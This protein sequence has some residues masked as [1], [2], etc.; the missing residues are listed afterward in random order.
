MQILPQQH[1]FPPEPPRKRRRPAFSCVQCRRR[2]VKCDREEPCGPCSR[3]GGGGGALSCWYASDQPDGN[4]NSEAASQQTTNQ[5]CASSLPF[6]N[7]LPVQDGGLSSYF[8]MPSSGGSAGGMDL[9]GL[10]DRAD[11]GFFPYRGTV[12]SQTQS[13][14]MGAGPEQGAPAA[15]VQAGMQRAEEP[16]RQASAG[17]STML[18]PTTS[19]TMPYLQS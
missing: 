6:P 19:S 3:L 8:S 18:M 13:A 9:L 12:A 16:R 14:G 1:M 4:A 17:K 10:P 2:K 11:A 5:P 7:K 15:E